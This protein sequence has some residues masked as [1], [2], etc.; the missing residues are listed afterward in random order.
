[1][2]FLTSIKLSTE[3]FFFHHSAAKN[4]ETNEDIAIKKIG[5]AFENR[6]DAKRILREI[7]L[8]R[9]MDHENVRP[10][11]KCVFLFIGY[12]SFKIVNWISIVYD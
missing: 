9:H 8:L 6:I 12:C 1:V 5:N 2:K 3:F 11:F 7:K 4:A 10:F